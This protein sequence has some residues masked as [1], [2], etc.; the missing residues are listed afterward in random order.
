MTQSFEEALNQSVGVI[1]EQLITHMSQGLGV[2]EEDVRK[3]FNSF[4]KSGVNTGKSSVPKVVAT[5][6]S[7]PK[8]VAVATKVTVPKVVAPTMAP[9]VQSAKVGTVPK[10]ASVTK[11]VA[12][13]QKIVAP[14]PVTKSPPPQATA[15]SSSSH[16]CSYTFQK[17]EKSGQLCPSQAK[18]EIDGKHFCGTHS[19]SSA[20]K[21]ATPASSSKNTGNAG[22]VPKV[23]APKTKAGAKA[24]ADERTQNLVKK[25]MGKTAVIKRNN[26]GNFI[27]PD[28]NIVFEKETSVAIGIQLPNG[29]IG[30]LT[31]EHITICEA[32]N[33]VFDVSRNQVQNAVPTKGKATKTVTQPVTK[34]LS[35][36]SR[37]PK[38]Q[39][40]MEMELDLDL[41]EMDVEGEAEED[42]ETEGVEPEEVAD[43]EEI[44][45]DAELEL[46]EEAVDDLDISIDDE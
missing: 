38:K 41:E 42:G 8:A 22:S 33:W 7:V 36:P 4:G 12:P 26:F 15:S 19:K 32:Q 17:G 21:V 39:E 1:N 34:P 37:A 40:A 14:P 28:T 43:V 31:E 35:A 24:V 44:D 20:P 29:K 9:K 25:I 30:P 16:T 11:V 2:G 23:V 18:V 10:V 46:G 13:T 27:N 6:V 45:L 5:K 3:V